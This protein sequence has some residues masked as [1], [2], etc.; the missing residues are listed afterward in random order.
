M[1]RPWTGALCP[2]SSSDAEASEVIPDADA[3]RGQGARLARRRHPRATR[4][5]DWVGS[6]RGRWG[7]GP[8]VST[9]V[10]ATTRL[11]SAA[12]P[13]PEF[14]LARSPARLPTSYICGEAAVP[15]ARRLGVEFGHVPVA[16][17]LA[18]SMFSH[19][20]PS[21]PSGGP[22]QRDRRDR[23]YPPAPHLP[24]TLPLRPPQTRERKNARGHD[25][26]ISP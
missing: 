22:R 13:G 20:P 15:G 4:R 26:R 18:L 9:G 2:E 17:L 21:C 16:W 8:L 1:L 12:H 19:A 10:R 3:D 11:C 6:V 7:A 24:L 25:E 23:M 14:A 5:S